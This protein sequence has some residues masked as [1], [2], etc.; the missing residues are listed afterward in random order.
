MTLSTLPNATTSFS[1]VTMAQM[2][3]RL[4]GQAMLVVQIDNMAPGSSRIWSELGALPEL[5]REQAAE[6]GITAVAFPTR[7]DAETIL[8]ALERDITTP[9]PL[10]AVITLVVDGEVVRVSDKDSFV[11][12]I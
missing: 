8:Q 7:D 10:A 4:T 11:R 1:V 2:L 3:S 5:A 6:D 12:R 9:G